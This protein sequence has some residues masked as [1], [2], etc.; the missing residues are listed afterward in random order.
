MNQRIALA[1][2]VKNEAH[3]ISRCLDSV[4]PYVDQAF[5]NDNGSTDR[6]VEILEARGVHVLPSQWWD[7]AT[8][9]NIALNAARADSTYVMC[10]LDADE[11][12][13]VPAGWA[14]PELTADAYYIECRY[15]NL[16]YPRMALVRA[17]A[18]CRWKGVLHEALVLSAQATSA[19]LPD[20]YIRVHSDGARAKDPKT[21]ENDLA[22]LRA[23]L[24]AEPDNA[25]YQFYLAQTLKD[26]GRYDEARAAYTDRVFMTGW[27]EET[28]YAEYMIGKM[29]VYLQDESPV[30]Y[31][32]TAYCWDPLRAEALVEL[33]RYYRFKGLYAAAAL[34]A[35][36]AA[37]L[38][39]PTSG[40]FLEHDVYEWRALDELAISAYYVPSMRSIGYDAVRLLR[41]RNVPEDERARIEANA[42]YYT[43][44]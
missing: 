26:M 38:P 44:K 43:R 21:A 13:V 25:R 11:E 40:L 36:Q 20:V 3:V 39:T 17:A 9:R 14:W 5:V 27:P 31:L 22:V 4:L 28:A 15:N 10:G 16:R 32:L 41:T 18:S 42:E 6:T 2:I 1:M 7:Y 37:L 24:E 19:T 30:Q 33:S 8:N 34:F 29:C 23:A 12:F 35:R